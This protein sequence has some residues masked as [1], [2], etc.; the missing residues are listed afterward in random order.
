MKWKEGDGTEIAT[1]NENGGGMIN[2]KS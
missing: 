2:E 1:E